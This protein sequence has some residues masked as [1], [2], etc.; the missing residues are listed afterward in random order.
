MSLPNPSVHD[1]AQTKPNKANEK[2]PWFLIPLFKLPLL[3][4]RLRLGWLLGKR[5]MLLTH[6][7]R[8]SGKVRR[9]I[10]AVLR[11][12]ETTKEIFSSVG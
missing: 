4:Y 5:F 3:L 2:A 9:T 1:L 12:D 10:L 11:F 8:R 7:G 6:V